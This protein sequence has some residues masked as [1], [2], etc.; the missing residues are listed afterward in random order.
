[1]ALLLARV[2]GQPCIHSILVVQV[3]FAGR[4]SGVVHTER[5]TERPADVC[6]ARRVR[7][8]RALAARYGRAERARI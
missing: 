4:R 8:S 1:M 3:G 5:R 7:S 6:R 2:A